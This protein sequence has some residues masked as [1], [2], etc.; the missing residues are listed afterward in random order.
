MPR[1]DGTIL[2]SGG[3]A[4]GVRLGDTLHQDGSLHYRPE[5]GTGDAAEVAHL[6]Q[7][8]GLVWRALVLWLFLVFLVSLAHALG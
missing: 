7:A 3:G 8:I 6:P 1:A 5:L 4:L 2:A